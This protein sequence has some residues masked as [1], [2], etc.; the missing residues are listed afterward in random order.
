MFLPRPGPGT[1]RVLAVPLQGPVSERR[2]IG[3]ARSRRAARYRLPLAAFDSAP[4]GPG[5]LGQATDSVLLLR[6][7]GLIGMVFYRILGIGHTRFDSRGSTSLV[8]RHRSGR[9]G[10]GLRV[11][12]GFA[13]GI[14]I[15]RVTERVRDRVRNRSWHET[16]EAIEEDRDIRLRA[17]GSKFGQWVVVAQ[18]NAIKR[19]NAA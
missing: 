2:G 15:A 17:D 9:A 1:R 16:R 12:R 18:V 10:G 6:S 3:S 13:T 5:R 14:D 11:D 19:G 4:A 7:N 8:R